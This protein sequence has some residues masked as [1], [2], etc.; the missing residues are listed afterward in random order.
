MRCLLFLPLPGTTARTTSRLPAP[1]FCLSLLLTVL[2]ACQGVQPFRERFRTLTPHEQYAEALREAGLAETALG[3]DW[4]GAADAALREALPASVPFHEVGYFSADEAQAAGYRIYAQRGQ[5]LTAE[6]E[7]EGVDPPRLFIDVFEVPSDTAEPPSH[8]MSSDST[9]SALEW[10]PRRNGEYLLRLQPE[11]LRSARYTV[12]VR[13]TASL[14]FPVEGRNSRAIGS[15]FG[16]ERDGG[17]RDHHGVDIFAPRG[18]PVLA[19]TEGTIT[20]VDDTPRGGKVV[21]LR[22]AKRGQNLYYAHLDSQLVVPNTRVLPGDTLGTVGNTGNARTTS[23]HLHF[24]IYRRGEGPV[25]PYPFVHTPRTELPS[26]TA[27]TAALGGWVRVAANQLPLRTQPAATASSV[28]DL[29]RHTALRLIGAS[30]AWHRV[31]LPDGKIGYVAARST[32]SAAV[33]IR[34]ERFSRG[35]TLRDR[36]TTAAAVITDLSAA[37]VVPVLARFEDFLLV[38]GPQKRTGWVRAE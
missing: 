34:R 29:P 36:P 26:L 9:M 19:A 23:P 14:A 27:D 32:E 1:V 30:G 28:A 37:S 24:G 20:R 7:V 33:P 25:D 2:T 11:L 38:E 31:R 8:L 10:E 16:D 15:V 6:V 3:R 4:L 22:D 21:W 18:T 13:S 5:R 35:G 17:R 12:T